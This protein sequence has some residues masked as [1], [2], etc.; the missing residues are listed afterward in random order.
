MERNR[1]DWRAD[2]RLFLCF[3][4]SELQQPTW[5]HFLKLRPIRARRY[6][7]RLWVLSTIVSFDPYEANS[8]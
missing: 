8:Q 4:L 2:G 1:V 5:H 6:R 7:L 3:A